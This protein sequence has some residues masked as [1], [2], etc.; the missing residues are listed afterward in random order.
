MSS[1][2]HTSGYGR[3]AA[4]VA[5][6]EYLRTVRRRGYLFGTLLLPLGIAVLMGIS[7]F[8]SSSGFDG[9]GEASGAIAPA[10]MGKQEALNK[11]S[12]NL[13]EKARNGELDP[14][15]GRDEE[16]TDYLV[17]PARFVDHR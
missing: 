8:F 13:T 12:V 16:R 4:L 15:V 3:L 5:R 10:Q 7:I 2:E 1:A 11:F 17:R 14:I 6:R 9:S